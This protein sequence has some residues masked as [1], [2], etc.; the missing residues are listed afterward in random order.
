[1][2]GLC[3]CSPEPPESVAHRLAH[4]YFDANNAAARHGPAAQQDFLRHT[5]HPDF[6]G[7]TC[8]LSGLTVDLI[9]AWSTLR[10]DPSFSPN[11]AR[12]RGDVWVVAVEVTTRREDALEGKQIGSQHLVFLDGRAYGFAPCPSASQ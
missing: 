7:Q 10:P 5:Q 4:E 9:P 12:P 11:G 3:A 6:L 2:L 1:M 8:E